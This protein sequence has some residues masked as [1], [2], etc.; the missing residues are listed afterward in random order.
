M[1]SA[2]AYLSARMAEAAPERVAIRDIL[3]VVSTRASVK[4]MSR[5]VIAR[6]ETSAA[7]VRP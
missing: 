3:D 6:R 5:V 1:T 4:P 2:R 7:E